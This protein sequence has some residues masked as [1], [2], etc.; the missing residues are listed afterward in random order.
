MSTTTDRGRD[1]AVPVDTVHRGYRT[2]VRV[3]RGGGAPDRPETRAR[4]ALTER[5]R[6]VLERICGGF[7]N[8]DIACDLGVSKGAIEATVQQLFRKFS[9]RTRV[10]LIR[11]AWE[12][13]LCRLG[14][15]R[16]PGRLRRQRTSSQEDQA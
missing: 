8:K 12:D 3:R 13:G 10:L 5:Q 15:R 14:T 4:L 7:S 11:I 6:Q 2:P 9:V 16:V 1:P